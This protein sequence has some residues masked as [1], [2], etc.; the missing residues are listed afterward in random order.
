MYM[1]ACLRACVCMCVFVCV[2]ACVCV[3]VHV[4]VCVCVWVC[5]CV[6]VRVCVR[7]RV[8]VCVYVRARACTCVRA[9]LH[10]PLNLH[11]LNTNCRFPHPSCN[12]VGIATPLHHTTLQSSVK[13][14]VELTVK[15]GGGDR[16][17]GGRLKDRGSPLGICWLREVFAVTTC[18]EIAIQRAV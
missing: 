11:L 18:L 17:K 2:C 7:V 13:G 15:V 8:C 9:C 3:C 5:V 12:A 6:C 16:R 1:C 14:E 4:C 10:A